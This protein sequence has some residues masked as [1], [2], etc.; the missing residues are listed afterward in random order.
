MLDHHKGEK[1]LHYNKNIV[2]TE[3]K[4]KIEKLL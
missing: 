4:V 2:I 1:E 3:I